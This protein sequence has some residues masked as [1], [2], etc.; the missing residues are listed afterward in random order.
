MLIGTNI[1]YFLQGWSEAFPQYVGQAANST[2]DA[3]INIF[4]ESYGGHYGPRFSAFLEHQNDALDDG[5]FALKLGTAP[6]PIRLQNLGEVSACIDY[7]IQYAGAF[8]LGVNNT[9]GI[10]F[11]NES[12]AE[13]LL[14]QYERPGGCKDHYLQ[15]SGRLHGKLP[16]KIA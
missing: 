5:S 11:L 2:A 7:P 4:T 9:Y 13:M 6:V 12:I 3:E 16:A 14:D 10:P 8:V 15:C 1:G